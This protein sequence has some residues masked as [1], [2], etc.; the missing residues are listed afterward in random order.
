MSRKPVTNGPLSG[1]GGTSVTIHPWSEIAVIDLVYLLLGV[2][3]LAAFV[4]YAAL[5]RRA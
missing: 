1:I 2:G 4:G 5:L 3:V